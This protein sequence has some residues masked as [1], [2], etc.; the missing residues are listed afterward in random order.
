AG[1]PSRRRLAGRHAADRTAVIAAP[2]PLDD[3]RQARHRDLRRRLSADG[4]PDRPAD[5]AELRL[6]DAV[7]AQPATPPRLRPLAAGRAD[8]A[9]RAAQRPPQRRAVP[10]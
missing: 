4:Q 9:R 8:V 6:A 10:P 7:L 1:P 2:Q 5:A 3:L